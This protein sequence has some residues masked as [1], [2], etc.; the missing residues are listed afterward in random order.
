M[1]LSLPPRLPAHLESAVQR[2]RMAARA[3]AEHT[4]DSLGLAALAST[5]VVQRDA[6]L[7]AQFEL[8]RKLAIF[9]LTFNEALDTDVARQA[10]TLVPTPNP[11]V[12]PESL[13]ADWD[14][15]SLVDDHEVE[16]HISADRFALEIAHTCEWEIRELDAYMG[17]L[18]GLGAADHDRN[19]LRAEVVARAMMRAVD[20]MSDRADVRKVLATEIGRSLAQ[21][22]RQTYTDVVA[23]LRH[24]GLKPV[25]L[26]VRGSGP[27]GAHSRPGALSARDAA[28]AEAT[29]PGSGHALSASGRLGPRSGAAG[30]ASTG[31]GPHG[32]FGGVAAPMM[33]LIRRLARGGGG[34]G[35]GGAGGVRAPGGH[36]GHHS[37]Y[38]IGHGLGASTQAGD[39]L[40]EMW[41][42]VPAGY[43]ATSMDGAQLAAP[44]LIMA[45]REELQQAATGALDPMVID[46]VAGLFDQILSDAKVPPQVARQIARL[47]LPVLRAALGDHSFFA[48][49]RHPVRRFVN[50]IASL[51]AAIDD[52][53]GPGGRALLARV[54]GLVQEVVDGDFDQVALYEHK[55]LALE[56]FIAAQAKAE[57]RAVGSAADQ[58][59]ARKEQELQAQQHFGQQLDSALSGLPVPEFLR[60]FLAQHWSRVIASTEQ[61]QGADSP[62]AQ[63]M[64]EVARELV[65]SVQ[66]KGSPAA[67]QQFLRTLPQLM[68]DLNT[69]LERLACP[70]ETRRAFFAQLL[71]AHAEAL[72]LQALS[73]LEH[74]LLA[75]Q[76]D[77]VVALPLPTPDQLPPVRPGTVQ[78]L[79]DQGGAVSFTPAEAQAVGLIDEAA[80]DWSATVDIDLDSAAAEPELAAVDIQLDGLPP[81]EAPE[82]TRGKSLADHVQIGFAYQMQIDGEWRKVRLTHISDGRG[83]FVFSH[84]SQQRQTVSLT[85]R[86]LLRL[87]EAGRLRAFEH[88]Q[89]I[90][91]ATARARRQ[92]AALMPAGRRPPGSARAH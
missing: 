65:M 20:A 17:T 64:R 2:V 6:L 42:A 26:S 79:V 91:R 28:D 78:A 51:G 38:G 19:P 22:L 27:R 45:Y 23:D 4:V 86:M 21:A 58:V 25:G 35:G 9:A 44:N 60:E 49:R 69:G 67:R 24:Q 62:S 7:G 30:F 18:L 74:N 13:V 77:G 33:S 76:V 54:A 84:G 61:R 36:G 90:E 1:D 43:V 83:F 56:A 66:P 39:E 88:A 12:T 41:A 50:R 29:Q 87:C 34:S 92:L 68:K 32:Q 82:P 5:S 72:K 85:H 40:A 46:V 57:L 10:G 80:V 70:E 8:N 75:R 31:L 81:A 37:G 71:P 14:K 47:Q 63:R 52:L 73:T 15:L 11:A 59:L 48:S 3:A 53:D 16:L 89:L 55:L